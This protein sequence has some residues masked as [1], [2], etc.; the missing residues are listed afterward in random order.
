MP[1]LTDWGILASEKVTENGHNRTGKQ[2]YRCETLVCS[3]QSFVEEYIYKVCKPEVRRQV[4]RLA[5]DC[6]GT[7]YAGHTKRFSA[8]HL[9][10]QQTDPVR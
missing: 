3:R 1:L 7:P 9:K 5:V 4:L 8:S 6:A 10:K 2:M